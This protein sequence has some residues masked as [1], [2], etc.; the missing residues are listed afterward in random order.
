MGKQLNFYMTPEDE[1]E[2]ISFVES[3]RT[4]G[5]FMDVQASKEIAFLQRL[6]DRDTV[7]WFLLCLWDK[8]HSPPP[9]LSYVT[10]QAHFTVQRIESE[11]IE[12][13]RCIPDEGRLVRGR[14]WAEMNGWR[15]DDPAIVI[16]KSESFRKWFS[17]IALW[18][19]KHSTQNEVGDYVL[20]G[21][22][23]FVKNGGKLCQAVL[24][25]GKAL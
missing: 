19:K 20:P 4:V 1:R 23:E 13:S 9:V 22:A 21:A 7:G 18:I 8:D 6:P 25:S 15:H 11:V 16:R 10:E 14:I 2:F 17:R 3:D 12:F 5:I 24:A